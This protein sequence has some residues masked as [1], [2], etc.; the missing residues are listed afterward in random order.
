[1][2]LSFAGVPLTVGQGEALQSL[3]R[4]SQ[5]LGV[6]PYPG[7]GLLGLTRPAEWPTAYSGET[8]CLFWPTG[9]SRWAWFQTLITQTEYDAIVPQISSNTPQSFVMSQ[10]TVT[11][12][13][14]LYA[15]PIKPLAKISGQPGL[16]LLTLV[17]ERYFWQF[18]A[19]PNE[20]GTFQWVDLVTALILS[21]S[22]TPIIPS[23]SSNYGG[24][25]FWSEWQQKYQNS[26]LMLDG[27]LRNVGC[28]L[29]KDLDG[30]YHIYTISDSKALVSRP[31]IN[32]WGGDFT[33]ILASDGSTNTTVQAILPKS[34]IVSFLKTFFPVVGTRKFHYQ[35]PQYNHIPYTSSAGDRFFVEVT[36]SDLSLPYTGFPYSEYLNTTGEA[37]YLDDN[38]LSSP[39]NTGILDNL[40][41]QLASDYYQEQISGLDEVYPLL[42]NWTMEGL[43]DVYFYWRQNTCCTRVKRRELNFWSGQTTFMH[44]LNDGSTNLGEGIWTYVAQTPP[45]GIPACIGNFP[46]KADCNIQT[47]DNT[48]FTFMQA[49]NQ[50]GTNLV[51][52]IYNPSSSSISGNIYIPVVWE[53]ERGFWFSASGSSTAGSSSF[54][55]T[56]TDTTNTELNTSNIT[57]NPAYFNL[58]TD[59]STAGHCTVNL[60]G[61]QSFTTVNISSNLVLNSST[62]TTQGGDTTTLTSGSASFGTWTYTN[63]N[64]VYDSGTNIIINSSTI[65]TNN[66]TFNIPT[67]TTTSWV[68]GGTVDFSGVTV[69][70]I[71]GVTNILVITG[72]TSITTSTL[73]FNPGTSGDGSSAGFS[74]TNPSGSASINLYPGGTSNCIQVGSGVNIVGFDNLTYD[75]ASFNL[76]QI[77]NSGSTSFT[78]NTLWNMAS[79][80]GGDTINVTRYLYGGSGTEIGRI[81]VSTDSSQL[82]WTINTGIGVALGDMFI[83]NGVVSCYDFITRHGF[84]VFN[85]PI[86]SV[87]PPVIATPTGGIVVDVEA[88]AAILSL[89]NLQSQAAGGYGFTA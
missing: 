86:I 15:L 28:S 49:V 32:L 58:A 1:M 57:V 75:N 31:S 11:L 76:T 77:A 73:I 39:I 7:P 2:E 19:F 25:C 71:T 16:Y 6:R 12:T 88:R 45:G 22:I 87:Q 60:N 84:S 53:P 80:L 43:H 65:T 47:L 18:Q 3:P 85:S 36:L 21:L 72:G 4:E 82:T 81:T 17:D 29:A 33:D 44:H 74:Q 14:S 52:T 37:Y 27:A 89:I 70:G 64:I 13:T 38:V 62:V 67:S 9:A 48:S 35:K 42:V 41:T 51:E 46:G 50:I 78:T 83:T 20:T 10:G 23:F 26:A 34:V 24:S 54:A 66:S 61:S 8:G 63:I 69:T 68:G 40:A 30:T 5:I 56:V 59:G 79:G 55:L